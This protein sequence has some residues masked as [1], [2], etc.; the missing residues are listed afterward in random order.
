[1]GFWD[2]I[3]SFAKPVFEWTNWLDGKGLFQVILW[4]FVFIAIIFL[5]LTCAKQDRTTFFEP[6]VFP[7]Q[8]V[9]Y[10]TTQTNDINGTAANFTE[11]T[12]MPVL[13]GE[14]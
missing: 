1:M 13:E 10:E 9:Q 14:S 6:Y 3:V 7:E 4:A 8:R 11:Q 2:M 12:P 5:L